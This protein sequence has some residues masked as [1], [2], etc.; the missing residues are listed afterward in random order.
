M[1]SVLRQCFHQARQPHHCYL[2]GHPIRTG[3]RYLAVTF[4]GTG[5][6]G[7]VGLRFAKAC[8]ICHPDEL[9]RCSDCDFIVGHEPAEPVRDW[10]APVTAKPPAPAA[11]GQA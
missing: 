7:W 9:C 3:D 4:R 5:R 2:C 6:D 11:G 8:R 10:L 1:A